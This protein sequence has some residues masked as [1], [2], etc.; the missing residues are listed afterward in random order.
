MQLMLCFVRIF[1]H[2]TTS[3]YIKLSYFSYKC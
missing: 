1:G 2:S 3:K